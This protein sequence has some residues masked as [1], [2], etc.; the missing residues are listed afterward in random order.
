MSQLLTDVFRRSCGASAPLE[1]NVTGPGCEEG[2]RR[3]FEYPFVLVGRLEQNCLRLDDEAVSRRHAYLQQLGGRV[4]C[5]DLDSRTGIHWAGQPYSAG[6]LMPEEGIQIG[7]YT[8]E[9]AQ[10]AGTGEGPAD[11]LADDWDPLQTPTSD[12][13]FLPHITV[14][15]GNEVKA[16]FCMNRVLVMVGSA[17]FCRIRL[18]D[19]RVS[20]YQASLVRTPQGVWL[21][22]LLQGSGA[23]LNGQ[24]VRCALVNE[25]DR[26]QVGPYVLRVWYPDGRTKTPLPNRVAT[27]AMAP[28]APAA[29][30]E[31]TAPAAGAAA[32]AT[33]E[34]SGRLAAL[35]A[36]LDQARA[37]QLK[38]EYFQQQL[39]E[40]RAECDRLREQAS[41]L[42]IQLDEMASLR[43][44]LEAAAQELDIIRGDRNRWQT[45][46]QNHQAK[47]AETAA[48]HEQLQQSLAADLHAAWAEGEQLQTEHKTSRDL[49]EQMSARVSDLERALSEA[50]ARH[51]T[52]MEAARAGWDAEQQALAI[53]LEEVPDPDLERAL[54]E[55]TARHQAELETARAGWASERQ[56]LEAELE[57]LRRSHQGAVQAAV[58]DLQA[59]AA[60]EGAEW[61][62]RFKASE[63]QLIWE[64]GLFKAQSERLHQ[65]ASSLQAERDRLAAQ[66]AQAEARLRGAEQPS[67]NENAQPA[68]KQSSRQQSAQ[69]Q[70]FVNFFGPNK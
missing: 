56:A 9:L 33:S 31:S 41:A 62:Q 34:L 26:L 38:A 13:R 19:S 65:Q 23:S 69:D 42:Q 17:P 12:P 59:Q 27:L 22:D 46:A 70:V 35:Q 25:K 40:S 45:E 39:S 63:Q 57:K 16:R 20:K 51:Q 14:E 18:R 48:E 28:T 52:D 24:S 60:A 43:T 66:L 30:E 50:T 15:V 11:W 10:S 61:R 2:E 55:A 29:A 67:P 21:I 64:R 54:T 58:G 44:R 3:I 49:A 7:P 37:R 36:E 68:D 53:E 5:V 8:V 47:L 6:W 4:F 32:A 1:L